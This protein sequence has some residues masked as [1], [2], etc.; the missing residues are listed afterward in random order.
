MYEQHAPARPLPAP[1]SNSRGTMHAP[2]NA[3][4]RTLDSIVVQNIHGNMDPVRQA[5]L[6]PFRPCCFVVT[7][8][9]IV[10]SWY[11]VSPKRCRHQTLVMAERIGATYTDGLVL[12][13]VLLGLV[14]G[15]D[16]E[17]EFGGPTTR[18]A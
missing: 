10:R 15:S 12:V 9:P 4:L 1:K 2:K 14:H 7:P 13:L 8:S 5:T 6:N 16:L 3:R 17:H 11:F 18:T